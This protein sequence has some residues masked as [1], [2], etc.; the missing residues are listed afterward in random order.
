MS[1]IE[2]TWLA[3]AEKARFWK[4]LMERRAANI[5]NNCDGWRREREGK[6]GKRKEIGSR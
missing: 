5:L 1:G 6:K 4:R 3:E 2:R